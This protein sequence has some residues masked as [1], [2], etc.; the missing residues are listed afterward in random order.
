MEATASMRAA[1]VA[2][3]TMLRERRRWRKNEK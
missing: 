2:A 3:A 1:A